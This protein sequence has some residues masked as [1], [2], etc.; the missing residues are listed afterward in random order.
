VK[1]EVIHIP[2]KQKPRSKAKFKTIAEGKLVGYG[3]AFADIGVH[4]HAFHY[5]VETD[6][7]NG[8]NRYEVSFAT[9]QEAQSVIAAAQEF[10]ERCKV[11]ED[12]D[13]TTPEES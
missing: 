7:P 1:I 13:K 12:K 3:L 10:I 2:T 4:P 11:K 5:I 8:K 6:V 9:L